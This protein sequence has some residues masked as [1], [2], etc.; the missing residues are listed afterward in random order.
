[1]LIGASK[2]V[3]KCV[4]TYDMFIRQLRLEDLPVKGGRS[5]DFCYKILLSTRRYRTRVGMWR[6]RLFRI[7]IID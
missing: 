2:K 3:I 7:Q 1:M 5:R 6:S 4:F